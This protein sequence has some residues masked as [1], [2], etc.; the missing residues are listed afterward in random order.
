[1]RDKS[2]YTNI[3]RNLIRLTKEI[4]TKAGFSDKTAQ[5]HLS[6]DAERQLLIYIRKT[7]M[8]TIGTIEDSLG[9]VRSFPPN[10]AET[11]EHG[12]SSDGN[13]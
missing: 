4:E 3:R 7:L 5:S 8:S 13:E 9:M 11:L 12:R 6:E 10:P 1:M 2:L